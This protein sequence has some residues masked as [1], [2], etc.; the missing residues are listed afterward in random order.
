[1]E[2]IAEK[3]K[4]MKLTK[5]DAVIADYILEN[6]DTIGILTS[7][8]LAE[9]IGVSDTSVIRF[10]RKLGFKGYSEFRSEMNARMAAQY[11]KDQFSLMPGEKYAQTKERLNQGSL[12]SDVSTYILENL[13]KSFSK[14]DEQV[15]NEVAD[16]LL[17][18]RKKYIAGFRGTASCAYYLSKRLLMLVPDVVTIQHADASALESAMDIAKDDCLVIFS[19]PRYSEITRSLVRMV[20]EAGAKVILI[21]DRQ[22]SALAAEADIV[23]ITKIEG[24]GFVNSYIVPFS[25]IEMILLAVSS[26]GK[27][28]CDARIHRM[29]RIINEEKLY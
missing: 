6:L 18:S 8:T 27:E 28:D 21:T 12:I 3:I 7:S 11:N 20:K 14:L 16:I 9:K 19:F 17:G 15:I 13:E 29:D 4:E 1:M 22:T 5:A 10:I 2:Q 25:V 26:R 24:L 23:I